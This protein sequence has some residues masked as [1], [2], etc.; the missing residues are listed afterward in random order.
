[1][2]AHEIR[3]QSRQRAAKAGLSIP[4]TLPLL[5]LG[6]CAR[7]QNEAT[8]RLLCLTAIAAAA[9]GFDK[10]K[11]LDWLR[12]QRLNSQL[13]NAERSFLVRGDG[14]PG[15]FR[16]QVEGMWALAWA[17][18]IVPQLD[19]WKDSDNRFVKIL[20]NLKTGE[21]AAELR[22]KSRMRCT[23]DLIA[24]CDLAYCLH[25]AIRQA[26]LESKESPSGLKPYVVV[27]RRRALEW[28]LSD[29][30]WDAVSLDT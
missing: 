29:E 26:E 15:S 20:P 7:S 23:D 21:S 12:Q 17:L 22:H 24:A 13:T 10:V 2:A 25:W 6:V 19:F 9:Y 1:M 18:N 4:L 3:E 11:A 8:N 5:D 27:E 28:L 30:S 14:D 16:T